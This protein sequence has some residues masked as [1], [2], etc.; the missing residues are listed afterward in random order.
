MLGPDDLVLCSGTLGDAPLRA[1]IEAAAAAGYTGI[2]LTVDDVERAAADGLAL[3]EVR[4]RLADAGLAVAELDPYLGWLRADA[5]GALPGADASAMLGRDEAAFFAIADGVGGTVLNCPHPLPGPVD[6]D[7]AAE[8]FAG[9]CDRAAEHGLACAIEFLPW[10]GIPDAATAAAIASRAGRAN[11]GIMLDTWHHFRSGGDADA[12][13]AL[14]GA[15]VRG[16]QVN[17][18]PREPHGPPMRETMRERLLPGEGA[19]DVAAVV[20]MLDAIGS[21]APIGVEVFSDALAA[22]PPRERA[23]R[24]ADAARLV[25]AA[26]RRTAHR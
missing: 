18:A 1:K 19:S 14:D 12:L 21:R 17:D 22:L 9:V 2:S 4:A 26:A 3:A 15:L 6:V 16:V 5:R 11:G 23:L 10:T 25:L 20:A 8:A 24:C 7:R 13:R